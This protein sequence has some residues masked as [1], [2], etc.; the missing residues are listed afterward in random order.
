MRASKF[1]DRTLLSDVHNLNVIGSAQILNDEFPI[2]VTN[3]LFSILKSAG[4]LTTFR[5]LCCISRILV[6]L[7]YVRELIAHRLRIA[8]IRECLNALSAITPLDVELGLLL[9]CVDGDQ[10]IAPR[11][12]IIVVIVFQVFAQHH[13]NLHT[14]LL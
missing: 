6:G 9:G 12:I 4:D 3:I 10:D 11:W 13:I 2:I 1:R 5:D 8:V 14:I 7:V